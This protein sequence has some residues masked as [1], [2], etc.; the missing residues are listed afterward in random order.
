[1]E[2][3]S[4][5]KD[6]QSEQIGIL[7]VSVRYGVCNNTEETTW[8]FLPLNVYNHTSEKHT[9]RKDKKDKIT[10]HLHVTEGCLT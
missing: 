4:T 5:N 6:N 3:N 8:M 10:L 7:A 9:D 2:N 1:M